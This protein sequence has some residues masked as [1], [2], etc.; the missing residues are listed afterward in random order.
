LMCLHFRNFRQYQRSSTSNQP[1][2]YNRWWREGKS[3]DGQTSR[4]ELHLPYL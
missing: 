2:Q 3:Q 1:A 4:Y